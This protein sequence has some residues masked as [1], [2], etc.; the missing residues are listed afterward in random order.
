[1]SGLTR[2]L[3]LVYGFIINTPSDRNILGIHY[4]EPDKNDLEN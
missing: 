1:M 2:V 3:L 4:E